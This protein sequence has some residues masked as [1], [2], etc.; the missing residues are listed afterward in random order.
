[1]AEADKPNT[2]VT[3]R[4]LPLKKMTGGGAE[5]KPPTISLYRNFALYIWRRIYGG[6]HMTTV[7]SADIVH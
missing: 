4:I 5:M 1:L 2:A 6:A 7:V 3:H